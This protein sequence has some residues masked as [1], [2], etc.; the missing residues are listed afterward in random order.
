MLDPAFAAIDCFQPELLSDAPYWRGHLPLAGVLVAAIQPRTIVELGVQNGDS[1]F[2]FATAM[3]R[4]GPDAG[5]VAGVDA[6]QGDAHVGAQ[7][8]WVHARVAAHAASFDNVRLIKARFNEAAAEFADR[9][10]DLLHIDGGH[11]E[12]DVRCDVQTWMPKLADYGIVLMHDVTAYRP[13]F[14][15][16]RVW[17][18][19]TESYPN[20]VFAHSAG[21]GLFA[22]KGV[23]EAMKPW[24]HAKRTE[25]LILAKTFAALGERV[26][27]AHST[28]DQIA[29]VR[30][31]GRLPLPDGLNRTPDLMDALIHARW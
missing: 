6:W 4:H 23:S 8:D 27:L 16:W 3:R 19:H 24:L 10:I 29:R 18:D 31:V 30:Q 5:T 28:P 7:S 21:L 14:G 15:V 1:L 26:L 12:E 11:S 13:D 22:P 9:S 20:L 17:Q 2:T 25:R